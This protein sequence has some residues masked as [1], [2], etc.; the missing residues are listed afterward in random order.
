MA[1]PWFRMWA[2]ETLRSADL[3]SL[4]DHEFRV[5][6][7][8]L[9]LAS[10]EEPRWCL[11]SDPVWLAR[12]CRSSRDKIRQT[13]GHL[14]SLG[15]VVVEGATLTIVHGEK[16]NEGRVTSPAPRKPSDLP[17]ATRERKRAQRQR[18]LDA[19][20]A[21]DANLCGICGQ[22][23]DEGEPADIDHIVP[24]SRGGGDELE[25]LQPAHPACNLQKGDRPHVTTPTVTRVTRVTPTHVNARHTTDKEAEAEREEEKEAEAATAATAAR[26]PLADRVQELA[27]A[28]GERS[29]DSE[30]WDAFRQICEEYDEPAVLEARRELRRQNKRPWPSNLR[31]V[32]P[33]KGQPSKPRSSFTG[34]PELDALIDRIA[35]N[36]PGKVVAEQ[37]VAS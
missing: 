16:Y 2:S 11:A 15:M 28:V 14:E 1:Q 8:L 22:E 32:L 18:Q 31:A 23:I 13:L 33:P 21:R 6:V 37:E 25:N 9:C 17:G 27:A 24:R 30:G 5:W 35:V 29:V 12:Q 19:L 34:N 4:T 3:D 36:G 10:L 26:D 7:N 20:L